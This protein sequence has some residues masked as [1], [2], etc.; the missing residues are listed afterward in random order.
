MENELNRILSVKGGS[1]DVICH[2]HYEYKRRIFKKGCVYKM[3]RDDN[4]VDGRVYR[5]WISDVN[6]YKE[7]IRFML[8]NVSITGILQDYSKYFQ[9]VSLYRDNIIDSILSDNND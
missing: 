1:I 4:R 8:S 3:V 6:D 5:V 2:T 9:V 7:G